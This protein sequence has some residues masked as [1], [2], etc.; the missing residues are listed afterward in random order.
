M[1]PPADQTHCGRI[2][3]DS[4][5][6]NQAQSSVNPATGSRTISGHLPRNE[7]PLGVGEGVWVAGFELGD[8]AL[9]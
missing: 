8:V 5:A 9:G 4:F 6:S 2:G 1:A 7:Q 3:S